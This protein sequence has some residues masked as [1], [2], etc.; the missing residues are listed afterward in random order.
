MWA[1]IG[2]GMESLLWGGVL[3][4][5]GLPIHLLSR[6]NARPRKINLPG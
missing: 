2:T 3:V 4:L 5:A 1:L 6:I